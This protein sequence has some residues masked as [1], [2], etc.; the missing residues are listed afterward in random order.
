MALPLNGHDRVIRN[1][2]YYTATWTMDVA[3]LCQLQSEDQ[4]RQ[5]TKRTHFMAWKIH[6]SE[7]QTSYQQKECNN[8]YIIDFSLELNEEKFNAHIS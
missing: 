1:Y 8:T 4:R 5:R 6:H 3:R 7:P 2:C